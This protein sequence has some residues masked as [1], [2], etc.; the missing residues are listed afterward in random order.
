MVKRLPNENIYRHWI[1]D[2]GRDKVKLLVETIN[3]SNMVIILFSQGY[4]NDV[5]HEYSTNFAIKNT[6]GK[7]PVIP[8]CLPGGEIPDQLILAENIEFSEEW[9][10][11]EINWTKLVHA[12]QRKPQHIQPAIKGSILYGHTHFCACITCTLTINTHTFCAHKICTPDIRDG[13][14]KF[15]Y[16]TERSFPFKT[17]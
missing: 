6:L 12:F 14:L 10:S 2:L 7:K 11:D 15:N 9:E 3:Q 5:W 13:G 1:Y 4:M 8:I 16:K 17:A